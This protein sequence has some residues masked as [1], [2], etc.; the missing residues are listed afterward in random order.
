MLYKRPM[1]TNLVLF[2]QSKHNKVVLS[3]RLTHSDKNVIKLNIFNEIKLLSM[4]GRSIAELKRS[5]ARHEERIT[6]LREE[7]KKQEEEEYDDDEVL[8]EYVLSG[9]EISRICDQIH[10][11]CHRHFRYHLFQQS[12]RKFAF[13]TTEIYLESS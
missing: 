1:L 3:N 5:I 13:I 12:V 11:R 9:K 8:E 2:F 10:T 4:I 7:L 6:V